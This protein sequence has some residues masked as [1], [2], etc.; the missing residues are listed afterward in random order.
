MYAIVDIET[1][2]G[3]ARLEKITEIAIY[4]HDGHS[5][6][7]EFV[8]LINPERNIPYYITSLTGITNEMVENAPKFYEVAKQIVELTEG[9]T[10]VAHNARFDYTFLREEFKALGFN[11]RRNLLDTVALSRKLL[12]GHKSYGL[13]NI[14]KDLQ[15]AINGRH[16]AYGDA[17]A[18]VKLFEIL[19]NKDQEVNGCGKKLMKNTKVSKLNPSLDLAKLEKI[20]EEPGVYYFYNDKHDLIYIGKSRNLQQRISTHLSNNTTNRAM[21]MRDMI[22]DIDWEETGSELI[23]LLKESSEIKMNKPVFNRA[24]RRSNY[25]WGIY[26]FF[27][28]HGYLNYRFGAVNDD[29]IPVSVFTSKEKVK[30]MLNYCLEKYNL[31]Q[32]LCGLY[33]TTGACFHHQVS[34]C[35]GACCGKEPVDSYNERA[36]KMM[37]EFSFTRKNFFIIDRGRCNEERCAVKIVNGKY[38]GYGYFNVNDMGFGLMAVHECIKTCKDNHDIQGILKQYLRSNKVEKIIEF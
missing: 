5:V 3:S 21:E 16:R 11:F 28:H 37:E 14:C 2:G 6:T 22:S 20:P 19:L 4:L 32:K 24:Q 23:A 15:I 25:Q 8:T 36:E 1:T 27:D 12:P 34:M 38:S 30:G 26:R 9:R 31:C 29:E 7:G 17:F 18:T 35:R 10:F 13:G 33:E